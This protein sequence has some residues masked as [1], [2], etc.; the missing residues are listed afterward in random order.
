M[1]SQ[2]A[3]TPVKKAPIRTNVGPILIS[4]VIEA[5]FLARRGTFVCKPINMRPGSMISGEFMSFR[6]ARRQLS[7]A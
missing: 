1:F 5:F 3:I 7:V 2:V 4:Y 6:S